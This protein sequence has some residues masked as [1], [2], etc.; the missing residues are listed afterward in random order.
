MNNNRLYLHCGA[1]PVSRKEV[2]ES[3]TP[4]NTATHYPI[5]HGTVLDLVDGALSSVGL[6]TSIEH[7]GLNKEGNDLF[8][9]YEIEKK[10]EDGNGTFTNAVGIRNSHI[11]SFSASLVAG[12]R[13]FVCDNL[14]ISGEIK[15]KRKLTIGIFDELPGLIS[16]MVLQLFDKWLYQ[17]VRYDAYRDTELNQSQADELL[18]LSFRSGCIPGKQL[19]KVLNEWEEP[20]HEEFQPRNAWSMFNAFTE[21]QKTAPTLLPERSIKLHHVFNGFCQDAIKER[22]L[23]RGLTEDSNIE[24]AELIA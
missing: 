6:H 12:G 20:S 16:N 17:E 5:P 10:D 14:M 8:A 24:E 22:M 19:Q 15:M 18:G 4:P 11:K 7:F 3:S 21:I 13:V 23:D 9:L 2:I 1:T